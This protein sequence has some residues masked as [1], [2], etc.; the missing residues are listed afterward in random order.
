MLQ[1]CFYILTAIAV[2]ML[3]FIFRYAENSKKAMIRYGAIII[4]WMLYVIAVERSGLLE[5]FSLPPRVV[6]LIV[7][8]AIACIIF[9]ITNRRFQP[10]IQ[11]VPVQLPI[12]LQS[13]RI[14]VELLIYYSFRNGI[15][16]QRATFEGLN[17]DITVGLSAPIIALLFYKKKLGPQW[18]LTWNILSLLVLSVTV[19]SF[20]ST[21]YFTDYIITNGS[22]E[23]IHF[24]YLLLAAVLLPA[25]IFLH[26]FSIRQ[27]LF[28]KKQVAAAV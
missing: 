5:N 17:F 27:L 8:P 12:F 16:P 28:R 1:I 25:A 26:V 11:S 10:L 3:L 20:I 24:P 7:L 19:Y 2:L 6:L 23:F 9:T 14:A 15:F 4:C 13:F 22:K 21:Y 18:L